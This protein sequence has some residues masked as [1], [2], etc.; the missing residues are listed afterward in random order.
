MTQRKPKKYE[1]QEVVLR[2]DQGRKLYSEQSINNV[3]AAVAV[4]KQE[5]M[6]YEREILC[7][8][9]LDIK[10]RPINFNIV[11]VGSLNQTIAE[12][13]YIVRSALYANA[14]SQ[15]LLHCHPSGNPEPS[16]EDLELT[17]RLV[18]AGRLIGVPCVDHIIVG[19]GTGRTFSLREDGRVDFDAP[20]REVSTEEILKSAEES[21][22]YR[23]KESKNM[24]KKTEEISIKFG[25]GLA[26]PF[27][28]KNGREY[29]R[30][31]IP[32]E[33]PGDHSPWASFVLPAKS[34][35]ENQYGKGLWAKIPA[36]GKTTVTKSILTGEKDGKRIWENERTAIPNRELKAR[37]EA[38]KGRNRDSVLGQLN[39][40]AQNTTEPRPD[41]SKTKVKKAEREK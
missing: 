10:L 28:G 1:L 24:D 23:G 20:Y 30:I 13:P 3:D 37:V 32:N 34:V 35:H 19:C 39:Q 36:D 2:L 41:A 21:A 22:Y 6:Q 26:K 18:Q 40:Y 27:T 16:A 33:D 29:L 8:V 14:G 7:V 17:R 12:I 4:M 5:L 9:N 25:K 31:Q 15:I 38:Y 11:S